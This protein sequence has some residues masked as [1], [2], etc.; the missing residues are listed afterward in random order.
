M[1]ILKSDKDNLE[2]KTF[3]SIIDWIVQE[4][5][6][7]GA[8]LPSDREF[9]RMFRVSSITV[10]NALD[11]LAKARAVEKRPRQGTYLITPLKRTAHIDVYFPSGWKRSL[12]EREFSHHSYEL[13]R[14]YLYG[15]IEGASEFN[16]ALSVE[17]VEEDALA[18]AFR[19]RRSI[20]SDGVIFACITNEKLLDHLLLLHLP[21]VR[22]GYDPTITPNNVGE[23]NVGGG[24]KGIVDGLN[25]LYDLGHRR[26][27]ILS[28]DSADSF[29]QHYM[30]VTFIHWLERMGLPLN[31]GS[32][33]HLSGARSTED[34]SAR[35]AAFCSQRELPT[36]ILG[37]TWFY[38]KAFLSAAGS[39][40]IGIPQDVSLLGTSRKEAL[41]GFGIDIST[42]DPL[43][44]EQA[45]EATR[46]ISEMIC[47][48]RFS[49]PPISVPSVFMEGGSFAPPFGKQL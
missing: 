48:D 8:K 15:I 23:G 41:S 44:F 6:P 29:P 17:Y 34:S 47:T 38:V 12:M 20:T 26:F 37:T 33:C 4:K 49:S 2:G 7:T 19:F 10:T 31:S 42:A 32:V 24:E 36:A 22:L 43:F 14:Q 16:L 1:N 35:I 39:R 18:D 28:R 5:L 30:S 21:H 9:G 27:G 40:G 25:R 13:Y 46:I 3:K 11:K 45:R